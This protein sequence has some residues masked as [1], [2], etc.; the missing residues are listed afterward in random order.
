MVQGPK[1]PKNMRRNVGMVPIFKR[2]SIDHTT[3]AES[4]YYLV[5]Y[6]PGV[7]SKSGNSNLFLKSW[8]KFI[9]FINMSQWADA[10]LQKLNNNSKLPIKQ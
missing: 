7:Y 2:S 6:L 3:H 5:Y 10:P 4:Y 1:R 9:S 8:K